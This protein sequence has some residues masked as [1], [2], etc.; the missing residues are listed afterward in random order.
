[1][2]PLPG[3]EWICTWPPSS[4][5][6]RLTTSMPTPRPETSLT[7]SAVEKPGAKIRLKIRSSDSSSSAPTRPRSRA[8][9]RILSR[10]QAAA[11]VADFDD[12]VAALV[13]GVELDDAVRR[14]CRPRG[15]PRAISMPWSMA[16]RTRCT[17][18]SPIFS[19]TV[20]S[21]SV[22]SP[23]R[24]SSIFLPSRWPRS[25]T[26]R[27]KRLNTK[28]IGS[29]RTRMTLSCSSRMWRSSWPSALRSSSASRPSSGAASWLSTDCVITSSPTEFSS[30]SIFSMLTRIEPPSPAAADGSARSAAAARC[31]ERRLDLGGR[32]CFAAGNA[33]PAVARVRPRRAS[34]PARAQRRH[35]CRGVS[36]RTEGFEVQVALAFDPVEHRLDARIPR[37]RH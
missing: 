22:L 28:L 36:R 14:A 11:V 30:S 4:L 9:A 12:D 2:L 19:S 27:G 34:G 1:M 15:A 32:G 25:R 23:V 21:S 10:L 7:T 33:V 31:L 18:G 8:L 6:L 17:S 5:M 20:L 3:V 13:I 29:M 37:R 26:R 35:R 24:R 16:L